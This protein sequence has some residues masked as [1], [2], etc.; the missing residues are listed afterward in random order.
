MC[1]ISSVLSVM[2]KDKKL[3]KIKNTDYRLL[4]TKT[5]DTMLASV[6]SL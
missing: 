3:F 6:V 1:G 2:Y 4:N 5:T